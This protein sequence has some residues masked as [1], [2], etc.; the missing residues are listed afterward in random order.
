MNIWIG[1]YAPAECNS[2]IDCLGSKTFA[3]FCNADDLC[4]VGNRAF[5]RDIA[6][7]LAWSVCGQS[8]DF[9]ADR[10][11]VGDQSVA[12]WIGPPPRRNDLQG[13]TDVSHQI[14][15]N[16]AETIIIKTAKAHLI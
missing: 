2:G 4:Q 13:C 11:P 3:I 5:Q 15:D 12:W 6:N 1:S 7:A 10:N 16:Q 14:L 8:L 9:G